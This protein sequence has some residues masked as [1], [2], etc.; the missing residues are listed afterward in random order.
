MGAVHWFDWYC[1]GLCMGLIGTV[2]GAV[3]LYNHWFDWYCCMVGCA[4][5]G[6]I[7]I[8]VWGAVHE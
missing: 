6:L 5:I 1:I 3:Q 2:W 8:V 7:G 4:C